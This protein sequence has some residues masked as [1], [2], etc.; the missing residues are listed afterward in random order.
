MKDGLP[1]LLKDLKAYNKNKKEQPVTLS[2]MLEKAVSKYTRM[3]LHHQ[4]E[5]ELREADQLCQFQRMKEI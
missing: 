4:V 5:Q 3:H 2:K 1:D